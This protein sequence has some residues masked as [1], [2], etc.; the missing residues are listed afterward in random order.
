M[1]SNDVDSF[2]KFP[3]KSCPL[4]YGTSKIKEDALSLFQAG[5]REYLGLYNVKISRN[6]NSGWGITGLSVSANK[7]VAIPSVCS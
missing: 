3:S 7:I 5:L 1:Q 2:K 6:Q 4:R